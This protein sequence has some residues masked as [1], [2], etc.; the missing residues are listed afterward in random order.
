MLR[1]KS[2]ADPSLRL[3]NRDFVALG[4]Q[5]CSAQDDNGQSGFIALSLKR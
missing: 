4:A 1:E 2:E 5:A 3:P